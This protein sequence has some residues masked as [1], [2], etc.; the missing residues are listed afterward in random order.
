MENFDRPVRSLAELAGV[1]RFIDGGHGYSAPQIFALHLDRDDRVV[2]TV[3]QI[4]DKEL[5]FTPADHPIDRLVA[6]LGE[7]LDVV[8]PGGS[9]ALMR[10]RPGPHRMTARDH[11]WCRVLHRHLVAAPFR[12]Q[13]LFFATDVSVGPVPSDVLIGVAGRG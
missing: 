8:A 7:T 12:T 3:I 11:D 4:Y 5:C 10:A 6:R 2:H 1:W 9:V 13:P